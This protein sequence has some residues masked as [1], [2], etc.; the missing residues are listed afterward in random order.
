MDGIEKTI[1]GSPAIGAQ[2]AAGK[3]ALSVSAP[4]IAAAASRTEAHAWILTAMLLFVPLFAYWPTTFHDFGL[5]DDYSN[6]R[7]AHEEPGAVLKF[8]ASHARPIYGLLLRATYGHTTSVQNLEW[9]RF[10]AALLLGVISLVSFRSLRALGWSY[11][12]GL[13]FALLVGLVPS[14]QV[15][16]SWAVGWPYA[17][18]ALLA[19]GGFFA[20]EGAIAAGNSTGRVLA[21]WGVACGLM[22]VSALIYQPSAMFYL[23]PVAAAF[24]AQ[25][26]RSAAQS[27]RWLAVHVG[28]VVAS[29]AL[30]YVLMSVL[31]ATG[32]FVKSPRIAFEQHWGTKLDWFL[33]EIV[34]NALSIFVLNDN[35]LRDHGLYIACAGLVGLLLILGCLIEWRR[36]GGARGLLWAVVLGGLPVL[37]CVVSLVASERYATY[38]TIFAMTAVLMLFG[39]ASV[40]ALTAAMR[41]STRWL[42]AGVLLLTAFLMAQHHAYA[43]IAVPQG[44]EW[45]LILDGARRV[46]LPRHPGDARPR[47]FAIASAPADIST[48]TIYHDEF[49]SLSSNSEWVP[50]EMFKRAMHDLHPQIQDLDSRYEFATGPKLPEGRRY[51][52]LIDLHRLRRYYTDN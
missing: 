16:A 34:P 6:L 51:D 31:Y 35:H 45:Q 4:P 36:H 12:S 29:L 8:C 42:V 47:I 39:I 15:I 1:L 21:Q 28:F 27:A 22:V 2:P 7:E 48:A 46:Q 40:D 23:V 14:A 50:R 33:G 49:G 30:T 19:V 18:A 43:L 32:A 52:V 5:R 13:C 9:M 3:T 11:G 20:A 44:N 25:R 38:R 41:A 26:E 24:I 10:G 17:I 37:A